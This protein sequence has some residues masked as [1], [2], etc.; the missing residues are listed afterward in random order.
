[1]IIPFYLITGFLG[2]GKTT[3]IKNILTQQSPE[4]KV[5][6]IQNEFAPNSIDG[7]ELLL[8]NDQIRI[9][10]INTGSVFC[11][12]LMGHFI[13]TLK[14]IIRKYEPEIIY[15]EASGL[16]NPGAIS[17]ILNEVEL[18]K[19]VFL[20]GSV[21]LVDAYNFQKALHKMP[22]VIQQIRI[23]DWLLLN[24]SDLV[25]ANEIQAIENQLEKL[26]PYA[27]RY[28]TQFAEI[29]THFSRRSIYRDKGFFVSKSDSGRPEKIKSVAIRTVKQI[30]KIELE[31]FLKSLSKA[32]IRAKGFVNLS[33]GNTI[34][35]QA[36]FGNYSY[37]EFDDYDANTEFTAIG[38]HIS[39]KQ[40]KTL[41]E[42]YTH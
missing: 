23:A 41:F 30:A 40:I 2:S 17:E 42:S 16:A 7:V 28:T 5:A 26:N 33:D 15:L 39:V 11:S 20:A 10:E 21:C 29:D 13:E 8:K 35:F 19:Q 32:T 3:F 12:C 18:S 22:L 14:S 24:K 38:E 34:L 1:M 27:K 36:V 31:Q 37:I 9:V 6:V 25:V 4:T